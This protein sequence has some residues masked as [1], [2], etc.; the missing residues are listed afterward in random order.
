MHNRVSIK[1][2]DL[3]VAYTWQSGYPGSREEP[4]EPAG[5]VISSVTIGG[6]D[7]TVDLPDEV[8]GWIEETL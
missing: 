3:T 6:F 5:P 8:L 4:V 1:E 7:V 2:L